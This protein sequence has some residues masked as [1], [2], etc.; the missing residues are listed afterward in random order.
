MRGQLYVY[1]VPAKIGGASTKIIDFLRMM[2]GT[3]SITVILPHIAFLK[4]PAVTRILQSLEIPYCLLRDL[5]PRLDAVVLAVCDLE[6]F[7]SGA[8]RTLKSKGG[9]I[10]WSNE[11]MWEF[12]GEA[13][14][15]K[16]G[17]VDRVLFLSEIQQ[18]AFHHIYSRS[19]S[20]LIRNYITPEDFPYVARNNKIFTIGRLSRPDPLKFPEDFPAFYESFLLP[21]VCYRVQAWNDE[22]KKKYRWHRFGPEWELLPANKIAAPKFLGSLDLFVYP[23]G[24]KFVESWGRS[25]VEAM[26]TGCI[27]LVPSGH[28]FHN[29]IEHEKTGF[30]CSSF[31]E[32]NYYVNELY[33]NAQ[34]RRSMGATS[35]SEVRQKLCNA[36]AHRK[37]WMEALSF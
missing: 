11:M 22:L 20:F 29:M 35:A 23:L 32:F 12:K 7:S 26:L 27:P 18:Q 34:L 6:F 30:I 10:V 5:P 8:A 21:E 25:A 4:D 36:E 17:I 14:A 2:K 19:D 15:V 31:D 3:Y 9:R 1:G 37:L 16:E 24:H 28:Q 33:D 13:E